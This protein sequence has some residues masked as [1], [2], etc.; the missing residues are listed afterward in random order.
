MLPD[1]NVLIEATDGGRAREVNP[2]GELDWQFQSP[3][4]A[5]K[6]RDLVANLYSLD[7]VAATQTRWLTS[8]LPSR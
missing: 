1:G 4:R 5:G 7:R 2:A 6:N 3:Y 8:E